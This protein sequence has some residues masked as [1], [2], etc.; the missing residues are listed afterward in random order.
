[1]IFRVSCIVQF[2]CRDQ[3]QKFTAQIPQLFVSCEIQSLTETDLM[4]EKIGLEKK[5]DTKTPQFSIKI[6]L[7]FWSPNCHSVF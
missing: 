4:K 7:A 2:I 5:E 6:S 3:A 1:M